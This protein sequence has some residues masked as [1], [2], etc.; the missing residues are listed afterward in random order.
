MIEWARMNQV[1]DILNELLIKPMVA[2]DL[3]LQ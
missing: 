3:D 2:I 1:T